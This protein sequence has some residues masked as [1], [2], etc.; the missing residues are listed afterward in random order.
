MK[1]ENSGSG[2]SLVEVLQVSN[3]GFWLCL[4]A[5]RKEYF[6]SFRQFPWFQNA[7]YR[8]LSQ[9]VIERGHILSWPDLDVDLDLERIEHPER[10]SPDCTWFRDRSGR[11]VAPASREPQGSRR[12]R[13]IADR[14]R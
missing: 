3:Q 10:F 11:G 8:Q 5:T 7:A 6:L 4:Q 14:S 13:S 12:G 9:L 1:S 2:T